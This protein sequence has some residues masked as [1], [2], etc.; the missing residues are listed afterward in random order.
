MPDHPLEQVALPA[1]PVAPTAAQAAETALQKKYGGD[2][3]KA[4]AGYWNAV[5][6]IK[7]VQD[8]NA[9]A[10]ARVQQL[11]GALMQLTG[12]G[13][14]AAV[15]NDPLDP[16]RTELGLPIEPFRNGIRS[17]VSAAMEELFGPLIKTAQAEEALST[18]IENFDQIKGEARRFMAAAPEVA[19]L[20]DS[21]RK[22][23]PVAAW[24]YAIREMTFA[25]GSA[26]APPPRSAG[27]PGG[28][29]PAGRGQANPAGPTSEE[30][31]TAAWDY[32]REYGDSRPATAERYKGTSVERAVN[33]TLR[34]LGLMPP[35]EG[36]SQSGW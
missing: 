3:G 14:A 19:G 20:F 32:Y 28:S 2:W 12:G 6:K 11:E 4:D 7:E 31:Q 36:G 18:E 15:S 16:I 25:K 17:E 21:L 23:D 29:T 30:K 26:P 13:Q 33:D 8:V 10:A 5:Q 35:E 27:L 34:R 9:A 1:E 24:K 22:A